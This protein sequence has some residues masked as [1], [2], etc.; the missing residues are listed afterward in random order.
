MKWVGVSSLSVKA[1]QQLQ[2]EGNWD[3]GALRLVE[4]Y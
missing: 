2:F 4:N 3:G 1:A